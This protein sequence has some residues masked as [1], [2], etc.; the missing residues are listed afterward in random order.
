LKGGKL[1]LDGGA[2]ILL[3]DWGRGK[4][5]YFVPPPERPEDLKRAEG[6]KRKREEAKGEESG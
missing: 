2:N 5:P 6:A 4:I 1:D 3:S